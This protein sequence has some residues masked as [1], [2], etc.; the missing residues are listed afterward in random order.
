MLAVHFGAGNIGRGF[1][2]LLL[3][4]AGYEV[5]FV[6]VNQTLV[7]ELNQRGSY[8]VQLATEGTP[9]TLVKGVRAIQGQDIEAVAKAIAQADLV[10]TAVGPHILQHIAGAIAKGIS[11]RLEVSA[12]PLNVI[13][14]ENMIGG[15]AQLKAQ[16]YG[17]LN[18]SDQAKAG[19]WIAFPNA[20]VDRIVPLQKHEDKLL[21]TVEPFFEWVVDQSQI[22]GEAPAIEGVTYVPDLAPYIE[23]KLFTVN[24]GHAVIAYLGYLYGYATID[25]A[26]RDDRINQAAKGALQETGALLLEKYRFEKETHEAYV[27]KILGRYANPML[28]DHVT[29]VA[30]S[31]IRKLSPNDR[32]VGPAMQC[33]ARGLSAEYLALAIAAALLFDYP[34][35][36]EAV[37]I[38]SER[39]QNGI[40]QALRSYTGIPAGNPLEQIVLEHV[41]S[42]QAQ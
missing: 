24:T 37:Q 10:T 25:E 11:Q 20:A 13:A 14:C 7:E 28:S 38:Q 22:V 40:D 34:E 18:E 1:I 21:V 19:Q 29:R 9:A 36:P 27:E 12:R 3:N 5:V 4:Q 31:P 6:D 2:G 41:R 35:D 17:H 16:V 32:L 23:R 39:A 8:H 30:R 26:L 42:L 33:V 15:S